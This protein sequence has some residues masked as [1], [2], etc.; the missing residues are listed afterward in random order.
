LLTAPAGGGGVGI[1]YEYKT[2]QIADLQLRITTKLGLAA[3]NRDKT[4]QA[5]ALALQK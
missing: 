4:H 5:K 2:R 3:K 1:S